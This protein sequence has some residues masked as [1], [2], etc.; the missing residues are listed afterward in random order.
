M[1]SDSSSHQTIVSS[2]PQ[3]PIDD[4]DIS[5]FLEA[6]GND[7]HDTIND[8]EQVDYDLIAGSAEIDDSFADLINGTEPKLGGAD[9]AVELKTDVKPRRTVPAKQYAREEPVEID[10]KLTSGAMMIMLLAEID[11]K[12]IAGHH[13]DSMNSFY[14]VG[15]KQIVTKVFSVDGR[16]TNLRDKTDE[17]REISEI[18]FHV[19]FTDINLA[20]PTTSRYKSGTVQMLMP[21][22]ARIKNLTYSSQMYLN[23]QISATAHRKTGDQKTRMDELNDHRIAPGPCMVGTEVCNTYNC[24][25]ETLKE[26]EEDPQSTG[27]YFIIKGF[28]WT[29]DNLENITNNTFH[30]Y[31]NTHLNEIARGTYL[32][33]PG[34]AYENS[35]QVILRY[36]NSGLIT[37]EITTNKFDKLEIPYYLLFR[38][39]GMTRDKDI[40][41][42]IVYGVDNTDPVT[43]TMLEILER[44]FEAD[45]GKF[46]AVRKSTD[47]VEIIG[48]I[49][50]RIIENANSSAAR[51]DE[52]VIKYLNSNILNTVDRFIF[53]HIGT[54]IEH[55]IK[56]LRFLGHLINKLLRV[57]MGVV[58]P[59]DR[60]SYR[61]KRVF[62]AGTSIAKAFKTDFNFAIVQEIRKHLTKDFRN[63][64]FSQ[65][66]LADSVKAAINSDDLERML[67]QAITS[68]NKTITV[69]RNEIT[70]RV[71]SGILYHKNDMNV[72]SSLG[73]INTPNTTAS[74]QN[75]R[76]DEMRRVHATCVGFVCVSQSADTG[77]KVGM[78]KQMAC[79]ASISG[80]SS[81]FVLKMIL[82]ED[83]AV[84]PQDDIEPEQI[85]ADKLA[86]IFVNGDW[87]GVC[88]DSHNLVRNYRNRRRHD[89]IHHRTTIVWE[90]LVREIYFWTD[91]GRM[92]RPLIIVYNNIE[93]Y[94]E[95]WR[96]GDRTMVFRQWI[97][98]TAKHS[99]LLQAKKI[100]I[101]DLR[102]EGVLEYI[103]PEEQ[104]NT[105]IARSLTELRASKNDLRRM[106][107]HCDVEQAI[108]GIIALASPR[109][110]HSSATRVTYYT[111]HRKQ[112]AGWFVLNF[113]FRID[114][115]T[116]L[117]HYCEWPLVSTFSD[118][119]TYPNGQNV[120]VALMMNGGEN[121]EDSIKANQASVD[122]GAYN[123]S[124]YTYEKAELEKGEQFGN[125]DYARTM[126]L[127]K[128]ATYEY[129]KDGFIA[130][131]T[132]VKKGYVL[133]VKTAKIAKPVDQY[134][135]IDKSV[136]YNRDEPVIVERVVVTRNDEDSPIA[137]TKLR[138][139]RPLNIGDKL[140]S[141]HGNKG[142][143]ASMYPRADAAYC[144]DGL[145][146]DLVINPHSIPTRMAVN[147]I[148]ECVHGIRAANLGVRVDATAFREEDIKSVVKELEKFGIKNGGHRR[149]YS[150]ETGEWIDVMIFIGP[151]V[152]QRLQK[153]VIDE[154]Q[155]CRTG[156]TEAITR[157]PLAGKN[158]DGSLRVGEMEKDVFCAHGTMRTL[159]AKFY[160]DSDGIDL[161]VCRICSNR[162]V[163]NEKMGIYKCKT[164]GDAADI[165]NVSSSW[166]ANLLMSET[167]AMNAK[168]TL[169]LEPHLYSRPQSD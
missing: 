146:P 44:A 11:R 151:T 159:F 64:P 36:L 144:E 76:A 41:N 117:Q 95:N 4:M 30:V 132:E 145:V 5:A 112:S 158:N 164:C 129:V 42:H 137:K 48:F 55:R 131:G 136:V 104:E 38:A 68:G 79:S 167:E 97:K 91:V 133:M 135:Y 12:K 82:L 124:F 54:G 134:R 8:D 123:A 115:N 98:Y 29:V 78:T 69:K 143:C 50:R 15:I 59:T 39:L 99:L 88:A 6:L 156:P 67:T 105:Y 89:D 87:I 35:Y 125:P 72:K 63:T 120:I 56:K 92:H 70:N 16:L 21:G 162:A 93:A 155:V 163:V 110:N 141:R 61:N 26:I 138:A 103:S 43:V 113:P 127:K 23:M 52:N 20:P 71:S 17:D 142:I 46:S 161:P 108:F 85:T 94:M 84:I 140:S 114:K 150:G 139:D 118:T 60:D 81:S 22:M 10:P 96:S 169:E 77:E 160:K 37:I 107:T 73:T 154:R 102:L 58:E 126:D 27:G 153:F 111:N 65:V 34:D 128:N 157:Q 57:Y 149:M 28:E 24:S 168:M 62:A 130:E 2:E 3:L 80:A 40:V 66:P 86:K 19:E 32:S 147:Q 101:D 7:G 25:M 75:E 152:Y 100:T 90:P 74:K 106:Y 109:A 148:I 31:K 45:D 47:P 9:A 119:L 53:P 83:A 165:V 18:S 33:K 121:Q 1:N 122:C 51:K 166:V 13:I 14:K 116:T 49:A